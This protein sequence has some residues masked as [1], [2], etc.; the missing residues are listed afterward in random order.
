LYNRGGEEMTEVKANEA[1]EEKK[2]KVLTFKTLPARVNKVRDLIL[3]ADNTIGSV[4]FNKRSNGELRKMAYRLH[5]TNPSAVP[6]PKGIRDTKTINS[7][8]LQL[9]VLDANK[10]VKDEDGNV[11]GKGA[12]RTIPLEKVKSVT[13]KRTT[14]QIEE[15]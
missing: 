7:K 3:S 13:V 14:Y 2:T 11:V 9:T 6:A 10:V 12:Y 15:E 4:E 8:N 5:V 1:K